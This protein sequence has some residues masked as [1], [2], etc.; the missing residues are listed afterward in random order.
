MSSISYMAIPMVKRELMER[1]INLLSDC[2]TD[3]QRR[4]IIADKICNF[5]GLPELD[6]RFG[7]RKRE[8]VKARQFIIWY[9]KKDTSYTLK[10]I[11]SFFDKDH[12]TVIHSITVITDQLEAKHENAYKRDY[13]LIERLFHPFAEL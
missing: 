2:L 3:N 12:T 4:K 6:V 10:Q 8:L 11:G 5:Y 13:Q 9:L 7:D 1:N